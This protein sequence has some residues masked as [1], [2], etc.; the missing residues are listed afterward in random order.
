[1]AADSNS[2]YQKRIITIPNILSFLRL[3][4]IPVIVWLYLYREDR[5]LSLLVLALSGITDLMDGFIARR[6]NMISDFGK[7]LDPV[8]DK[9]TQLA[10]LFC[11]VSRFPDMKV[12]FVFFIIKEVFM[13]VT[14]LISIKRTNIVKGAAWHGKLTTAALYSIIMIH[15]VW[16]NIPHTL[17]LILVGVCTGIMLMSFILYA[18]RNSRAIRNKTFDE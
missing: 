6:Y 18:I 16:Y 11:L 8:A 2:K 4:L 12:P 15:L 9:L 5:L 3:C 7:A 17:S 14:M 10:M 13:G 1:M